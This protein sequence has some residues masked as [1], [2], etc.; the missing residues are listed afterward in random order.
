MRR[1]PWTWYVAQ[2]VCIGAVYFVAG[3]L[4][5]RLAFVHTSATAVWAPT[6]IALAAFLMLGY[7]VWPAILAGAF[8]VNV[9]TAGSWATSLS[10]ATGNT[11]EGLAGAY[12]V[13]RFAGGRRAFERARD[14]FLFVA[15]AAIGATAVSATWGVTT[16][17]AS[18]MAR[19]ADAGYIWLTWWLGD[20]TGALVVTPVAVL[21]GTTGEGGML[22]PPWAGG[23][24][25]LLE[26][27]GLVASLAAMC[28]IVFGGLFPSHVKDYPLEFLTIPI[29]VWAAFRFGQREAATAVLLLS[30]IAVWG[31][32]RGLGPFA[33]STPNESLLLLQSFISVTAVMTAALAAVVSERR[34]A[35]EQ[36]RHLA[37]TDALTGLANYRQLMSVLELEIRRAQRTDRPFAVLFLDVDGLKQINDRYGHL[38]GSRALVRVADALRAS[39]RATDTAARFGGDEFA[40]VLPETAEAA[41]HHVAARIAQALA[42]DLE[43]PAVT[44]SV[45]IGLY[46]R[47][48]DTSKALF[49]AADRALYQAKPGGG[50]G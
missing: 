44:A 25:R 30:G 45:G 26:A 13:A 21:W 43:V 16:L 4:G 39:C 24:R 46:P 17:A 35:E 34:L 23:P 3:K 1:S 33:R 28:A 10:I 37:V 19:W 41:A 38:V 49:G 6:G 7:G 47:D 42:A 8:L 27:L 50:G 5:L 31:T 40:V 32:V 14:V 48:G 36:L 2:V 29:L 11:L 20:A 18:G 9:T 15:L 22:R 12:L